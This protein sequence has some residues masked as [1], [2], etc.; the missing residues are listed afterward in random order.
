M[1]VLSFHRRSDTIQFLFVHC[2]TLTSNVDLF[3]NQM[4][5]DKDADICSNVIKMTL[6]ELLAK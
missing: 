6:H 1:T 5:L 3:D 2:V 4:F